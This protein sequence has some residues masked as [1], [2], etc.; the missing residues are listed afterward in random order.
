MFTYFVTMYDKV[1]IWIDRAIVGEQYPTIAN[2]LD[3]AKDQTDRQ[4][5]EII[6]FGCLEGLKVSVYGSGLYIVGSLPKYLH[7]SNIYPL[8]RETTK[9]AFEK[10][11][12]ALHL[13]MAE[14]KITGFEFGATFPMANKPQEYLD[15]LGDMPRLQRYRFNHD[16]LYFRHRGKQQPK[17]FCFYDKI[18]EAKANNM[19]VPDGLQDANLLRCELRLNGRLPYQ[20]GVPEVTAS[21]LSEKPFY[22]KTMQCFQDGYFS[23]TKLNQLKTDIMSEIKTVSD[24]FDVLVAR[25][26]SQSD[27]TQIQAFVEE[28]KR[29]DV[30]KNRVN[31]TRLK[32]KI[33]G[34]L[35]K[36]NFTTSDELIKELDDGFK[37]IGA[38]V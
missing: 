20:M 25:L 5:G 9:Q 19:S 18:A 36:A 1:N 6:T 31:Y 30:F 23:I 11:A 16:T 21:T 4:T 15:R 7:G 8:S 3:S 13:S 28:I 12:D 10:M 35:N 2:Y 34:V 37:N 14:A 26:I 29:A 38:Y 27:K 17:T 22:R 32:K 24:A 33:D